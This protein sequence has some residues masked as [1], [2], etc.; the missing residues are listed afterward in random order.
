MTLLFS[1]ILIVV[2]FFLLIK[3]A[4]FLVEGA[5][6]LAHR[7]GVSDLMIG[8]TIV[9]FGT[10]MPELLVNII[11]SLQGNTDIAIGNVVGSNIANTFL[12][13]GAAACI[14][15]LYV[16]QSTVWKEIPLVLLSTVILFVLVN[17]VLIDGEFV[18]QISRSEGM[19]LIGFFLIFMYYTFGMESVKDGN[20]RNDMPIPSALFFIL[21]GCIMLPLGGKLSVDASIDI[22]LLFGVSEAFIGLS[23]V[24]LGTSLPE[25]VTACVATYRGNVDMAMGNVVGSNIFNI[26]WILGASAI[27]RPL[28]FNPILNPDILIALFASLLLLLFIYNGPFYKRMF[29]LW[30]KRES[31]VLVRYEGIILLLCYFAYIVYISIRG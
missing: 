4:N 10:S 1:L 15:P 20:K 2:G 29:F 17:D 26:L 11:A 13:L 9:A 23:I 21:L 5:S 30:R 28:V 31:Y 19:T 22:A 25:L 3:G 16:K 7:V 6:V 8:L 27:I 24:A 12:V 14:A 18:A